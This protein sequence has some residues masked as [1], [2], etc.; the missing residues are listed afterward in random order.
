MICW[1]D[2]VWVAS[3]QSNMGM[4]LY[5]T[6]PWTHGVTDW[7]TEIAAANP[8]TLRYFKTFIE[9]SETPKAEIHGM[10]ETCTPENAANFSAVA[11]YFGESLNRKLRVPV[12]LVGSAVGATS[13]VSWFD[14]EHAAQ[15]PSGANGLATAAVRR[16]EAGPKMQ[17]YRA[18]LPRY[19]QAAR[20]DRATPGKLTAHPEPYKGYTFQPAGCYNAMIAPLIGLPISGIIWYQSESDNTRAA[21]YT[22]DF[23]SLIE[24]WRAAWHQPDAPFLFVQIA[25]HDAF[26]PNKKLAPSKPL[27]AQI[28]DNWPKQRLAQAAALELPR[29]GMAVS[30]DFGDHTTPRYPDKRCSTVTQSAT[31]ARAREKSPPKKVN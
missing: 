6:P 9:A 27:P 24:S 3:G 17:A 2:E 11:Y 10:W 13:I 25:A 23:E 21:E 28:I 1:S 7:Q 16:K 29:T 30:C 31:T 14:Q 19:Y 20:E 22:R 18:A 5:P 15:M 26:A 8:P 12:G 4:V